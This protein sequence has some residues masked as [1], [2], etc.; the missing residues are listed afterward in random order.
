MNKKQ[1]VFNVEKSHKSFQIFVLFE[2]PIATGK[3]GLQL[4]RL[5]ANL[6]VFRKA[7]AL[8]CE[9]TLAMM[10][11]LTTWRTTECTYLYYSASFRPPFLY[12]VLTIY[13]PRPLKRRHF[14]WGQR[15]NAA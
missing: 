5:S 6:K 10:L 12:A 15:K 3:I 13:M 14:E 9:A 7:G 11:V 4:T 8:M 2:H 1:G